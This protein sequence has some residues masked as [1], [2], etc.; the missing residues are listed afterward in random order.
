MQSLKKLLLLIICAVSAM[1]VLAQTDSNVVKVDTAIRNPGTPLSPIDTADSVHITP[2]IKKADTAAVKPKK[3]EA[4]KDSARLAL[5]SMTRKA[6][7]RSAILP[8]LGQIYNGRWWKVPLVYG[9]FVGIG[10]VYEFNQR[11][12]KEFLGE[13]QYRQATGEPKNPKYAP[14]SDEGIINAKDFYRRNRDL[15]ILAGVA[16]YAVQM[17]DAYVDAKFF[18]FDVSDEL[19]LKIEPSLQ[20]APFSYA[21]TVYPGF[22]LKLSL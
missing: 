16:F 6:V 17:I 12:Y 8:G 18:R 2:L 14:Y 1:P 13:A 10:L 19:A 7:L 5:E 22:K 15:S 21:Y 3:E 9:G 20:P 4:V 11:Y